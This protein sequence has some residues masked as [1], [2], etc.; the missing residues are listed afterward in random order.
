[1]QT[2]Y[3][4]KFLNVDLKSL[5]MSLVELNAKSVQERVLMKRVLFDH[6]T[7]ENAFIRIRDEWDHITMTWKHVVDHKK[8]DG[9]KE[10]EL[11]VSDFNNAKAFINFL[12][13]STRSY[14]ETYR[15]TR[16][17]YD[18]MF[19][20]DEWPWIS[21]FL[22]IEW[23]SEEIVRWIAE[24]LWLNFNNAYFGAVDVIYEKVLWISKKD[25]NDLKLITFDNPPCKMIDVFSTLP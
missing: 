8:V 5:R 22:E 4:A 6:P 13:I 10:I 24:K 15:E 21:P 1:M 11:E 2:E 19:T 20:I 7:I 17:L 12:G 18:I 3:E 16:K 9:T 25:F 23:P 14:Q